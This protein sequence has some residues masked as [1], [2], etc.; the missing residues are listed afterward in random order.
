MSNVI[1]LTDP[2]IWGR[3]I[4]AED[5]HD[6]DLAVE[7]MTQMGEEKK[8]YDLAHDEANLFNAYYNIQKSIDKLELISFRIESML[9]GRYPDE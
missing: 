8:L 1:D 6:V 9:N 7:H 3:A 5:V 2:K 4:Y